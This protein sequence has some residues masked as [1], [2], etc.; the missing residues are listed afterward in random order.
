MARIRPEDADKYQ[1]TGGE[2]FTLKDD[3]DTAVVYFMAETVEDL[4]I[5]VIHKVDEGDKTRNVNCLR[6]AGEPVDTCP[7]CAAG[8]KPEVRVF[9][10]LYDINEDK[11]KI[12]DRGKTFLQM[13]A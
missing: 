13:I 7:L 9:V 8:M 3:K 1:N 4:D 6:L 5:Y 11:V 12:W 10:Q 2:F